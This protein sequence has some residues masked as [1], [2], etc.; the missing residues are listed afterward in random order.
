MSL[1]PADKNN[2]IAAC[3]PTRK[4]VPTREKYLAARRTSSGCQLER[5]L[6][7]GGQNGAAELIR[8]LQPSQGIINIM[9]RLPL[10]LLPG[11]RTYNS[12]L[13]TPRWRGHIIYYTSY[14]I[15]SMDE[16]PCNEC[17]NSH[18]VW[19]NISVF[20][21]KYNDIYIVYQVIKNIK[22]IV[23]YVKITKLLYNYWYFIVAT[24]LGF[25][26][27]QLTYIYIYIVYQVIKNMKRIVHYVK[28]TTLLY[29]Y[30]YFIVATWLGFYLG[31]LTYIYIYSLSSNKEHETNSSLRQNHNIII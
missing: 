28:I 1:I 18:V 15:A 24:W 12:L 9:W 29:N 19:A 14:S 11:P 22:R 13:M 26:L 3:L 10:S 21:I 7:W 20:E 17:G 25:Y 31:Q 16:E 23:H 2:N 5:W 4:Y 8:K 30:W 6:K 27:G